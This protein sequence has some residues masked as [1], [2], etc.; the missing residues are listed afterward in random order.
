MKIKSNTK[1]A[2]RDM[3]AE[4][5]SLSNILMRRSLVD[6]GLCATIK[7]NDR[8][9][10]T[11]RLWRCYRTSAAYPN[12]ICTGCYQ[13]A[14]VAQASTYNSCPENASL[15]KIHRANSLESPVSNLQLHTTFPAH[16]TWRIVHHPVNPLY[17]FILLSRIR[18]NSGYYSS[19]FSA[20]HVEEG[21][22][23][24]EGHSR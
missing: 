2:D 19:Q 12:L 10:L 18:L 15:A 11:K 14:H 6:R 16:L 4:S 3:T 23:R 20:F 22:I 8:H 1:I 5:R 24:E 7:G 9:K 13:N 17:P 21:T